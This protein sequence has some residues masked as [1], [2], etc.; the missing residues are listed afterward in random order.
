[1]GKAIEICLAICRRFEGFF[2]KPYLCPAKV[3][4]IGYGTTYY[5]DGT[6]VTLADPPITQ[7]RGEELLGKQITG[8]YMRGVLKASPMLIAFPSALGALSSFAYNLGVPRYRASTLRKRVEAQDWEGA[9][10]EIQR[11][12][13]AGGRVLRGLKLRRAVEAQYLNGQ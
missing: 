9:Q 7:E 8:I 1:M 2:S 5:E 11:W 6:K 12:N 4:T 13:R 3:P 10:V